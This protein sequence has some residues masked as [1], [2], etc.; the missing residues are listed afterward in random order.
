[1]QQQ[2]VA[3]PALLHACAADALACLRG[4]NPECTPFTQP[5]LSRA[6]P[7]TPHGLW[8]LWQH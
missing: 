1:M 8:M 5:V 4:P 7:T 2:A 3:M 6:L